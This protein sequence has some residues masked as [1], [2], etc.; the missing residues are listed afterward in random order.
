MKKLFI[1]FRS[2]NFL[3]HDGH[4][5]EERNGQIEL[6]SQHFISVKLASYALRL[7][8]NRRHHR[9]GLDHEHQRP[10]IG[11]S[12]KSLSGVKPQNNIWLFS[13]T[14]LGQGLPFRAAVFAESDIEL[15]LWRAREH[16]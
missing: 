16:F 3:R 11:Q 12:D 6:S 13:V 1:L 9:H 8:V 10:I 15:S 14:L 2:Y 4:V 5:S 7:H